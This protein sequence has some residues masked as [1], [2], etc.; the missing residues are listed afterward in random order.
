MFKPTINLPS[1]WPQSYPAKFP[2]MPPTAAPTIGTGIYSSLASHVSPN[3]PP[4]TVIVDTAVITAE[5]FKFLIWYV[6]ECP[7]REIINIM[8]LACL[9]YYIRINI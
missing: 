3:V 4:A 2:T 5:A 7:F 1:N 8:L 9:L 6:F